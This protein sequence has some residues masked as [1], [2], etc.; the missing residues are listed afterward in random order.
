MHI[1]RLRLAAWALHQMVSPSRARP[2]FDDQSSSLPSRSTSFATEA[3][4]SCFFLRAQH[5]AEVSLFA[6]SRC[7]NPAARSSWASSNSGV[8]VYTINTTARDAVSMVRSSCA[9]RVWVS[10]LALGGGGLPGNAPCQPM[11]TQELDLVRH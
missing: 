2:R 3:R 8:L 11:P 10:G 4:T 5:V 9:K 1:V 6:Q 7:A